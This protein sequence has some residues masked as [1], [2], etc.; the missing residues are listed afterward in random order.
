MK[1]SSRLTCIHLSTVF[2]SFYRLLTPHPDPPA[3]VDL[4]SGGFIFKHKLVNFFI[5]LFAKNLQQTPFGS[6]ACWE[7]CR[8]NSSQLTLLLCCHVRN[9]NARLVTAHW[10]CYPD[11][12][13]FTS[14]C[15]STPFESFFA[16]GSF[17][18]IFLFPSN[19]LPVAAVRG[20]ASACF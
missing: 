8:C 3:V 14:H 9:A 13:L 12:S 19:S 17:P 5:F 6:C 4:G 7:R 16:A 11:V 20:R 18:F 10:L 1:K 15:F 2:C